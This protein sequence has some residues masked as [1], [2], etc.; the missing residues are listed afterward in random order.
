[1]LR[2]RSKGRASSVQGSMEGSWDTAL[3]GVEKLNEPKNW[4]SKK[5]GKFPSSP[6][7]Q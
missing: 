2:A 5:R 7:S 6:V 3:V 4:G 1:M